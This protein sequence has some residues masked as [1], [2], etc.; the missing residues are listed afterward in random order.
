VKAERIADNKVAECE[1]S[2]EALTLEFQALKESDF[3][4][5]K[6]GF[7]LPELKSFNLE[8]GEEEKPPSEDPEPEFDRAAELQEKWG[9]A[10]GQI[11]QVGRHRVMCGDSTNPVHVT[12]LL[13]GAKPRVMIA[14]PPYGIGLDHTWRDAAEANRLAPARKNKVTN[15][16][17]F[18]WWEAFNIQPC[19]IAYVWNSALHGYEV[20]NSLEKANY[21][22]RQ[23][24]IW[25]K[26]IFALSRSAYQWKHEPCWY[27]VRKGATANWQGGRDKTTVWQA[28]SPIMAFGGGRDD[29][30]TIHPT[31]KP[32][33]VIRPSIEHH[34][35][36]GDAVYDP[37]L[38]SGTTMV[39]AE[40]L[41][42]LCYGLEI[43]P[44]YSAVILERLANMGLTPEIL[45]VVG[46]A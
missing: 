23:Q 11:W 5:G 35:G 3:D 27:A 26:D 31:Q 9:T 18:E 15:D 44:E 10:L 14:D 29:C 1:W 7:D 30:R 8:G 45:Q 34:T 21:E 43:A 28:A 41:R 17:R 32:L 13:N 46:E 25:V 6:T 22:I 16:D 36:K 42:R 20:K 12:A 24:I 40:Q 2:R 33:D 39:A 38:G 4:L 37:F 19:P